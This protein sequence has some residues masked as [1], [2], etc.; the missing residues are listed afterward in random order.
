MSKPLVEQQPSCTRRWSRGVR[1]PFALN[2]SFQENDWRQRGIIADS[3]PVREGS[4]PGAKQTV[5]RAQLTG[6]IG[7]ELSVRRLCLPS[8]MSTPRKPD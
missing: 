7:H 6:E 8:K 3:Q 4:E 1:L 2:D 5:A